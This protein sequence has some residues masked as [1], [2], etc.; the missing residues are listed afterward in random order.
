ML[1]NSSIKAVESYGRE[2]YNLLL[3]NFDNFKI[4][5]YDCIYYLLKFIL[6]N[7]IE[8]LYGIL[9]SIFNGINHNDN[10]LIR[11][12]HTDRFT[13]QLILITKLFKNL[14]QFEKYNLVCII[15]EDFYR[16]IERIKNSE[17]IVSKETVNL[18]V[19]LMKEINIF[20]A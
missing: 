9:R 16:L 17:L 3:N 7:Q 12:F 15:D 10:S 18:I 19:D 2:I 1:F 11:E 20:F 8:N 13:R 14:N 4:L 6:K 5:K